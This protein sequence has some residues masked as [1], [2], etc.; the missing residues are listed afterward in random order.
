MMAESIEPRSPF[1][2]INLV[3]FFLAM[4]L[5]YKYRDGYSKYICR[6][7][8]ERYI[9]PKIAWRAKH[10]FSAPIW[11]KGNIIKNLNVEENIYDSNILN[12]LPFHK[13][14]KKIMI[15]GLNKS[16]LLWPIFALSILKKENIF[17]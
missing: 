14:G 12:D 13:K 16:K 8:V 10:G 15:K 1:L 9:G 4:P 17:K 3:N 6:K 11:N 7:M 5:K 2:N